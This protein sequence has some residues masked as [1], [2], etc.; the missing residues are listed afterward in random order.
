MIQMCSKCLVFPLWIED[1]RES[2]IE[3]SEGLALNAM[4]PWVRIE[5]FAGLKE[6]YKNKWKG[7][8]KTLK[9]KWT[10][11]VEQTCRENE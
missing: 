7:R 6:L 5:P 8:T 3:S 4:H 9:G 11:S 1:K 2:A 10:L